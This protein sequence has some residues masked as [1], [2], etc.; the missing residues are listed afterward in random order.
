MK[1]PIEYSSFKDLDRFP[2]TKPMQRTHPDVIKEMMSWADD[3][4]IDMAYGFSATTGKSNDPPATI[5]WLFLTEEDMIA[6]S[7][8]FAL[9]C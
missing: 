1:R 8:F 3:Q 6:F 7:I 9:G 4:G 2:V 5:Y